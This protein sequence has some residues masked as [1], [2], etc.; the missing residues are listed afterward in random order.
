MTV[1]LSP[2]AMSMSNFVH[3]PGPHCLQKVKFRT[4]RNRGSTQLCDS[5]TDP[6]HKEGSTQT[7]GT[8]TRW[9]LAREGIHRE[10][11]HELPQTCVSLSSHKT[12]DPAVGW[13]VDAGSLERMELCLGKQESQSFSVYLLL[14]TPWDNLHL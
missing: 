2:V 6:C 8:K 9:K 12:A 4:E 7:T 11:L 1:Y 14:Y 3:L 10:L 5:R 13:C